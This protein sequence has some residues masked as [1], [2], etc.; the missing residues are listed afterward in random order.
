MYIE[1]DIAYIKNTQY[2]SSLVVQ[3]VKFSLLFFH[4]GVG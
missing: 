3:Q 4:S 2:W 1:H